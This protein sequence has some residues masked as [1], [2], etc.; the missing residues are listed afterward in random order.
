MGSGCTGNDRVVSGVLLA[1]QCLV[2]ILTLMTYQGTVPHATC[3]K[4]CWV[5]SIFVKLCTSRKSLRDVDLVDVQV[6]NQDEAQKVR[7][8]WLCRL[9]FKSPPSP[10]VRP[11][12]KTRDG[13]VSTRQ[14]LGL[15]SRPSTQQPPAQEKL[16]S[17]PE[18]KVRPE[19]YGK[20]VTIVVCTSILRGS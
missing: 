12:S 15:T 16:W 14:S 18:R 9:G 6:A 8:S 3:A 20:H 19:K 5:I 2:V 17:P 4:T 7:M 11:H 13:A 1:T 10:Q